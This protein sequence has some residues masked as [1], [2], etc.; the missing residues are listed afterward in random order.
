MG[1]RDNGKDKSPVKPNKGKG[2]A[3]LKPADEA[4]NSM[5]NLQPPADL[6]RFRRSV[7]MMEHRE[8]E[9]PVEQRPVHRRLMPAQ[10]VF[11]WRFLN[12]E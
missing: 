10:I 5:L 12:A 2:R 6:H 9:E 1:K 8:L 11:Q 3:T 4:L 7:I